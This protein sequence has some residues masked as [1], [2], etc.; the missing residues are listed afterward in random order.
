MQPLSDAMSGNSAPPCPPTLS[1]ALSIPLRIPAAVPVGGVP[2]GAPVAGGGVSVASAALPVT[3]GALPPPPH[4][5]ITVAPAAVPAPL[6]LPVPADPA[7]PRL[8]LGLAAPF[9]VII[10][11]RDNSIC[12][13][14]GLGWC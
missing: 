12:R 7:V 11:V 9:C 14:L 4:I 3:R 6:P 5:I 10:G 13:R 1:L 8:R 2:R